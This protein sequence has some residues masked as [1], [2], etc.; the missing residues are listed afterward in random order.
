MMNTVDKSQKTAGKWKIGCLILMLLLIFPAA[1]GYFTFF[2]VPPRKYT[3][4]NTG[5]ERLPAGVEIPMMPDGSRVDYVRAYEL[6]FPHL[7]EKPEENAWREIVCY[8]G[9][10][11][12]VLDQWYPSS[13]TPL[14]EEEWKRGADPIERYYH[15]LYAWEEYCRK[16]AIS[17]ETLS[18]NKNI[19]KPEVAEKAIYRRLREAAK[20]EADESDEENEKIEEIVYRKLS[21]TG[22]D[23]A[24]YPEMAEWLAAHE[25]LLDMVARAVRRERYVLPFC[26]SSENTILLASIMRDIPFQRIFSKG[27]SFR[28]TMYLERG[29]TEKALAEVESLWRLGR[30]LR[31]IPVFYP[32]LTGMWFENSAQLLT[33]EILKRNAVSPE[34]L[35]AFSEMLDALP[36]PVSMDEAV[37]VD[38]WTG[39]E[40]FETSLESLA[41][42]LEWMELESKTTLFF[43]KNLPIDAT[44]AAERYT[45]LWKMK[46][47]LSEEDFKKNYKFSLSIRTR[48]ERVG[49]A[50]YVL[51]A[52]AAN[53]I[54]TNAD[55]VECR[56]Q[57]ARLSLSL[58]RYKAEHGAYPDSLSSLVPEYL[59]EMPKTPESRPLTYSRKGDGFLLAAVK[60]G[61]D[62]EEALKEGDRDGIEYYYVVKMEN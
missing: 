20:S 17:P 39:Y 43:M 12:F 56:Y 50:V 11:L 24:E 35:R 49:E 44:I 18:M 27:F 22:W 3:R 16:L 58:K 29:E 38:R 55:D 54:Y 42:M 51:F 28:A 46:S 53:A 31:Q 10:T 7:C 41:F 21:L 61:Y 47:D 37:D 60:P 36:A 25:E 6:I 62:P 1:Y 34:Q 32:C 5:L 9:P 48:S 14:T 59:A 57:L 26:R 13:E 4:E 15:I 2:H 40:F 45:E 52:P 23:A 30:H 8:L 33:L 19:T